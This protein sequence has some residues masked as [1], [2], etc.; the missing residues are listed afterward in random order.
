M[1]KIRWTLHALEALVEREIDRDE[2]EQ[3]IHEP[4]ATV[5]G[6]GNRAVLLRRYHDRPL[7]Q[8]MLLCVVTEEQGDEVVIVTIYKTSRLAKR[9]KGG[10]S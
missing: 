8:E 3:A 4:T 9:F 6:H 2:A 5:P 7:G 1:K 10:P